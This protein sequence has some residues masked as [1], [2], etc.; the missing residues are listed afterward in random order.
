MKGGMLVF[1]DGIWMVPS[2]TKGDEKEYSTAE[3]NAVNVLIPDRNVNLAHY[4]RYFSTQ[5]L[6]LTLEQFQYIKANLKRAREFRAI[7]AKRHKVDV[8]AH[9]GKNYR[10]VGYE[11][12]INERDITHLDY[13]FLIE[14]VE[15]QIDAKI[16]KLS[17]PVVEPSLLLKASDT[18]TDNGFKLS[19]KQEKKARQQLLFNAAVANAQAHRGKRPKHISKKIKRKTK[20][21]TKRKIRYATL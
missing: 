21:K 13:Y 2:T 1:R 5:G 11:P 20:R 3:L 18:L 9:R 10:A 4:W 8:D 6:N 7:V 16:F 12:E 15:E 19:K 14:K 17:H